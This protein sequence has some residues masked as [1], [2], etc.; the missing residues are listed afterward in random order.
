MLIILKYFW[1]D[2]I[3][4][5]VWISF[6]FRAKQKKKMCIID[7]SA[8]SFFRARLCKICFIVII[9]RRIYIY[10]YICVW[11]DY[12]TKNASIL[13][14]KVSCSYF[15]LFSFI[16]QNDRDRL[17]ISRLFFKIHILRYILLQ[18]KKFSLVF[19]I[20]RK[21]FRLKKIYIYIFKMGNFDLIRRIYQIIVLTS[22]YIWS[23]SM[24]I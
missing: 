4:I 19:G 16:W 2:E 8:V 10:I 23:T 21:Y 17:R 20:A 14:R 6:S 12:E 5:S 1:G 24:R 11:A 15:F 3:Y 22:F 7:A 9:S 18:R 13:S